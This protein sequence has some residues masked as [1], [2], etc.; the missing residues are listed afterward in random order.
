M[1]AVLRSS[2]FH[3]DIMGVNVEVKVTIKGTYETNFDFSLHGMPYT[4][5]ITKWSRKGFA[6]LGTLFFNTTARDTTQ[7]GTFTEATDGTVTFGMDT[8]QK[9]NLVE[10][11]VKDIISTVDKIGRHYQRA[12]LDYAVWYREK[13]PE[14]TTYQEY[15]T[16]VACCSIVHVDFLAPNVTWDLVQ[17]TV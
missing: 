6:K 7:F 2:S 1:D 8:A 3:A 9:L 17:F 13:H 11:A 14:L 4:F 15:I 5:V 10:Q 12:V 16:S